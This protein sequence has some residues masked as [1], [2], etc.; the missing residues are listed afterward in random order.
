MAVNWDRYLLKPLMDVFGESVSYQ[1]S[2][3]DAY[4]I[5]GVF[6]RAYTQ[7][8]EPLEEGGPTINTTKPVLGVRDAVFRT[9]P[10]RGDRVLIKRINTWFVVS[11][12]QPDSHG[13]TRL[14]LNRVKT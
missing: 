11:D 13:G 2:S 14:E 3:G 7:D 1:P 12:V 5:T 8:V 10:A 4:N 9:P 6:D